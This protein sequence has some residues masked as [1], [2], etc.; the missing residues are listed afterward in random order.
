MNIAAFTVVMN[1]DGS[2][3][4]HIHDEDVQR[5]ATTYDIFNCCRELVSDIESQMLANRIANV[6]VSKLQPQDAAAELKAKIIDALN[7]RKQEPTIE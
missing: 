4:T 2:L 1:E 7:D 6:V 3:S 5:K